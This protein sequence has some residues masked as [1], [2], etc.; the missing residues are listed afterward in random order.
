MPVIHPLSY[1]L[2]HVPAAS[3][4]PLVLDSPHSGT[5]YP[6]DFASIADIGMLRTAED[7]WVDDLWGGA[8]DQGVPLLGAT[9]PRAYIDVNRAVQ[10]IDPT[11]LD[12]PWPGPLSDSPKVGLG[13][14]LIWRMLDDGTPLYD[15]KLSVAEVQQRI[16]ACWRPYHAA[17]CTLLDDTH[18]RLGKVWHINCHSMP[19]VAGAYATGKP[20]TAHP[21][22]VLGDRDGTTADPAFAAFVADWLRVRGYAVAINDPYKGVELVRVHGRPSEGRHS[23]QIEINRKL[24]MDEVTLRPNAGY[25]RLKA[26]LGELTSA[27]LGWMRAQAT[28]A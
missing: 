24:Y 14:G 20:G 15:R 17:L 13:K 3:P 8:V 18:A 28:G 10:D 5:A 7:T 26:T 6:P 11:M 19:S 4:S 27:M 2:D 1:R 12:A 22:F 25:G 16:D 21:D 23:L 9:C